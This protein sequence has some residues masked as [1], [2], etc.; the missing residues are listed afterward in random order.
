MLPYLV[1]TISNK[2][3]NHH[4]VITAPEIKVEKKFVIQNQQAIIYSFE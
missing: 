2:T 3:H 4:M 1:E